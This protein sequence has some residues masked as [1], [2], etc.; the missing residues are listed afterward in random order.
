[1]VRNSILGMRS[2]EMQCT[3]LMVGTKSLLRT[4]RTLSSTGTSRHPTIERPLAVHEEYIEWVRHFAVCGGTAQSTCRCMLSCAPLI[5]FSTVRKAASWRF[6][7]LLNRITLITKVRHGGSDLNR[8][9][10]STHFGKNIM[11]TAHAEEP[12]L[13]SICIGSTMSLNSSHG[14]DVITPV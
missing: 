1:M 6:S 3:C 13:L 4:P 10:V 2:D 8:G 14:M 11:A 7:S 9:D 12:S 5:L